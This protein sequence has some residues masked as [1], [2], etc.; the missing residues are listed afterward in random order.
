MSYK[1]VAVVPVGSEWDT[2]RELFLHF[3]PCSPDIN[4]GGKRS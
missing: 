1:H 4:W 2:H 3:A